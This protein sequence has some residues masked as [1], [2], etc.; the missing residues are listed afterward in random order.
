MVIPNEDIGSTALQEDKDRF[1]YLREIQEK[2]S[3]LNQVKTK[4]QDVQETMKGITKEGGGLEKQV[5]S[6]QHQIGSLKEERQKNTSKIT[7]LYSELRESKWTC[8]QRAMIIKTNEKT[9]RILEGKLRVAEAAAASARQKVVNK[10][11]TEKLTKMKNKYTKERDENNKKIQSLKEK[12]ERLL[13]ERKELEQNCYYKN[14]EQMIT[15]MDTDRKAAFILDQIRL[16][17]MKVPRYADTTLQECIIWQDTDP[18]GYQF[19]RDSELLTLPAQHTMKKRLGPIDEDLVE[20]DHSKATSNSKVFPNEV[21]AMNDHIYNKNPNTVHKVV[22]DLNL[23]K[24]VGEDNN[25]TD[26]PD[27]LFQGVGSTVTL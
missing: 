12:V 9:I 4:L 5:K 8:H 22:L 20:S 21:P 14:I 15:N 11:D 16:Y 10:K 26:G 7:T 6:V 27:M 23:Q 24:E 25:C 2:N 18:R 1:F 19:V 3:E 13:A 17:N